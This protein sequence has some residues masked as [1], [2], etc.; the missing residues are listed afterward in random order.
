[1]ATVDDSGF[2]ALDTVTPLHWAGVLLAAISGLLHLAF[3]PGL[4]PGGLGVGFVVA[5][6]GFLVGGAAVLANYRR[7]QLY[8][9]GIPFTLGQIVLWY[10]V[11]AP[12]FSTFGLVDKT[13]QILFVAVVAVL[14]SR[15][16]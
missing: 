6:V 8:L 7:T 11:N 4:L 1:M 15:E 14:Y 12:N 3:A 5:G 16:R 13:A 9:L 2:L 10:L